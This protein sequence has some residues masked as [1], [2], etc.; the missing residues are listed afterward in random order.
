[1]AERESTEQASP[2]IHANAPSAADL[3]RATLEKI[4]FFEWRVR[5]LSAELAAAQS[6]AA[7]SELSISRAEEV[8][9][10][11]AFQMQAARLQAAELEAER[12]R[13]ASLL[14]RPPA[15]PEAQGNKAALE[16]ERARSSQLSAQLE[17]AQAQIARNRDERQRWLNEMLE[18]ARAGDEAPAALAQFIS[19]LRG[20]VIALRE[21]QRE[22]DAQLAAAGLQATPPADSQ[23]PQSPPPTAVPRREEPDAVEVARTF[24]DEGRLATPGLART[25]LAGVVPSAAGP[26]SA[27]REGATTRDGSA[28]RELAE[29]CLRGLAALDPGRRAQAARHLAALPV[30]AASPALASA[31]G[32]ETDPKARAAIARALV[33]CGGETAAEMVARLIAPT[34]PALVRLAA[35]ESLA[36]LGGARGATAL[37]AA[38]LDPAPSLRRRAAALARELGGHTRT[39]SRLTADAN[40]SVR[41][42]ARELRE[43]KA[44]ETAAAPAVHR[45]VRADALH[46]IRT[47]IFGLTED[48]LAAAV[49]LS[50]EDGARLVA[51]LLATGFLVRRGRRLIAGPAAEAEAAAARAH[52]GSVSELNAGRGA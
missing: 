2:E 25:E 47:A 51:Q 19:E 27:S 34:E 24:W 3:L 29:Q 45:D 35:L 36:L 49:R 39:L 4:V 38:A 32:T 30:A 41:S 17:E 7:A 20:E 31:L 18:Q 28:A 33:A 21:R 11:A 13:L 5:E 14:A 8:A 50:A 10:A 42:A 46:A 23:P 15:R 12:A 40:A 43:E 44:P 6:R 26:S 1:V 48:E 22:T 37:E 16:A 52:G 9:R